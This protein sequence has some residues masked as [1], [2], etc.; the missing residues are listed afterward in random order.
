M[1]DPQTSGGLLVSV[2][3]DEANNIIQKLLDAGLEEAAI[4][5]EVLAHDGQYFLNFP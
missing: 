5:G 1:V 3:E 2:P 4:I